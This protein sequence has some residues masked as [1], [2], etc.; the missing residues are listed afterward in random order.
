MSLHNHILAFQRGTG[1]GGQFGGK[2]WGGGLST[3]RKARSKP[4]VYKGR[5][6]G[7]ENDSC[8]FE[9]ST[10]ATIVLRWEKNGADLTQSDA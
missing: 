7:D 5:G 3:K 4:M 10:S 9:T 8:T 1:G 6:K 2:V